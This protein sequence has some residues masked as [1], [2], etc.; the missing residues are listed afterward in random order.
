MKFPSIPRRIATGAYDGLLLLAVLFVAAFIFIFLFGSAVEPPR[1]YAFQAYLLA[2]MA[3]YFVWFWTHGG[4]TLA[5]RTWHIRLLT[6]GGAEVGIKVASMRFLLAFA[7]LAFFG[8]GWWWALFDREHYFLHDRLA[9][10]R[11]ILV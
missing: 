2:V 5:M 7:G 1:R 4:Q 8:A 9:G 10:T 3:A 11:L 6:V